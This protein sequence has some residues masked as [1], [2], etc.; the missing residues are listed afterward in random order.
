M[1]KKP[2]FLKNLLTTASALAV[3]TGAANAYAVDV[4]SHTGPAVFSTGANFKTGGANLG[5]VVAAGTNV[6]SGGAFALT[7]DRAGEF[8]SLNVYG[9]NTAITVTTASSFTSIVNDVTATATAAALAAKGIAQAAGGT[10]AAK[11]N[12]TIGAGGAFTFNAI[13]ALGTVTFA[14][15]AAK[16]TFAGD[17]T[18]V[19]GAIIGNV[20]N[21]GTVVVDATNVTFSGNIGV[22][23]TAIDQFKII[24]G[25]SATLDA[26]LVANGAVTI[27]SGAVGGVLNVNGGK[28][29]TTAGDIVGSA[30][31]KGKINF[32]GDSVVT[33]GAAAGIGGGVALEEINIGAGTVQLTTGTVVQAKEINLTKDNS[34]LKL[35]TAATLVTGDIFTAK[36]GKGKITLG[37]NGA[38]FTGNI[39]KDT[40]VLEA[41]EFGIK[42]ATFKQA[43][44]TDLLINAGVFSGSGTAAATFQVTTAKNITI[45]TDIGT[46]A[47]KFTKVTIAE[48]AGGGAVTA[49]LA[50]GKTINA[51]T[52]D[53]APDAHDNILILSDGSKI[54]GNI[55]PTTAN[56]GILKVAGNS[57]VSSINGDG[58]GAGQAIKQIQ[59]TEAG[60]ALTIEGGAVIKTNESIKFIADGTLAYAGTTALTIDKALEIV[61][62]N[63]DG[64]GSFTANKI[65]GNLLKFSQVIGEAAANKSL[66]LLQATGG[67]NVELSEDAYIKKLDIGTQ[68]TVLKLS[69]TKNYLIENF[70]HDDGKG[71]LEIAANNVTLKAGSFAKDK[72]LKNIN[73]A[74]DHA[75]NIEDGVN[76]SVAST[77]GFS[78][79]LGPNNGALIFKGSSNVDA[80]VGFNNS[81]KSIAVTGKGKIVDFKKEVKL[82]AVGADGTVTISDGATAIFRDKMTV[83]AINGLVNNQGIVQVINKAAVTTAAKIGDGAGNALATLEL[84]GT[85]VTFSTDVFKT[86]NLNFTNNADA[87]TAT[88]SAI[89]GFD[90]AFI[91]TKITTNSTT[92]NHNIVLAKNADY[93]FNLD[94][95]SDANRMG[96]FTIT[97]DTG[98]A[99]KGIITLNNAFYASIATDTDGKGTVNFLKNNSLALN[100]GAKDKELLATNFNQ[101]A[102]VLGNIYS[103]DITVDAGKVATFEK[104]VTS[105]VGMKLNNGS[106]AIFADGATSNTA[107]NGNAAGDGT[108]TFAGD[109]IISKEIGGTK[110]SSVIFNGAGK[111]AKL[112]AKI[113]SDNISIN[114]GATVLA[115]TDVELNGITEVLGSTLDLGTSGVTFNGGAA[116]K[117]SGASKLKLTV[118]DDT[119]AS[120]K[121]TV[122]DK[123]TILNLDN[124][125]QLDLIIDD[126][127]S[128]LPK[129][130][131]GDKFT[132]FVVNAGG[133]LND[134]KIGT[135]TTVAPNRFVQWSYADKELTRKNVAGSALSTAVASIKDSSLTADALALGNVKN[136]GDAQSVVADF[137]KITN[138]TT[139]ADAVRRLT[140]P[141]ET[142]SAVMVNVASAGKQVVTNRLGA[143]SPTPGIQLSDNNTSGVSAGDEAKFGAWVSPFLSQNNQ[144]AYKG[145]AGYKA[146]SVGATV[147]F[148]T[149]ANADM[150]LGLAGTYAKTD[151][152]HK[153]FKS[154]DKTKADTFMFSIYGIQ[155]LTNDWFLQAVASFS[156]SKVKNTER[157]ITSA[158]NK[159]AKGSFDTTTYGG[160]AM[161]GYNHSIS[162]ATIT[163]MFGVNFTRINDGGYK[164]TGAD[165][166]NLTITR[167]AV[168]KFEL[169]GGVKAQM[170][171][172]NMNGIDVTPE[173]HGF[174]K[175]DLI[176][177]NPTTTAKLDGLAN[178]F[179]SKSAKAIKTSYN[180]GFGMNAVS[181]MYEYGAGYDLSL[182]NKF[183][184]HQGTLKVR[185]NF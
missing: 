136:T 87:T 33:T 108:V 112:G 115:T 5:G 8:G 53:I 171:S 179:A 91:G 76:F 123:G 58:A 14:D 170:N 46:T 173:I 59:F 159:T 4:I 168:N 69:A 2:N 81:L 96:T 57:T 151:V 71:T 95:G 156:S 106:S 24:D 63:A 52:F 110:V 161:V 157:R 37:D 166:Q 6:I 62:A 26:N 167:K 23:G 48:L 82:G 185:V 119:N 102:T 64:T 142:S 28:N 9:N 21:F 182:A 118:T 74:G 70:A 3:V 27:G 155:Q 61:T 39:G 90:N 107:I 180:V 149:M 114:S 150:T 131:A 111:T 86:A 29:I 55:Q 56:T 22:A 32:G 78:T 172:Y 174:V 143:L 125:T 181:G 130:E 100:L 163:P 120:G 89:A 85:D 126:T 38:V 30:A 164:E 116:S 103:K 80:I 141:I 7:L 109:A 124:A 75:L 45:N 93:Q 147:G 104:K 36:D 11:A 42:T 175:H 140:K 135:P 10:P 88:F 1:A 54:N 83:N 183:V 40:A 41:V 146:T 132:L 148:D 51:A 99:G 121:I 19:T 34:V 122:S 134:Q 169:V 84:G 178:P 13:D 15:A 31:N 68:D 158:G 72:S 137:A 105:S 129:T 138:D 92:Q 133:T 117:F 60:K 49:T 77:G 25:K 20:G 98:N 176:G 128:E 66:K 145:S 17:N 165:T 67:A 44:N 94:V 50:K 16:A 139:L 35:N 177:K 152:K 43:A 153:N 12:F 184:G 97:H 101:N 65:A 73:F 144:S 79:A 154:S 127:K 160:D 47:S 113:K 162:G 18:T